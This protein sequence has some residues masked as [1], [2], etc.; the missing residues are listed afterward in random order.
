MFSFSGQC[1]WRNIACYPD[2]G[3]F[4]PQIVAGCCPVAFLCVAAQAL[5]GGS[6]K[7]LGRYAAS[8]MACWPKRPSSTAALT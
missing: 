3:M 7:N 5:A 4:R 8:G 2:T 6:V 1:R